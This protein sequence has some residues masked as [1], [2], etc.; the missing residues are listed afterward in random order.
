MTT[1]RATYE[2]HGDLSEFE[3]R[4]QQ[5][6]G[7]KYGLRRRLPRDLLSE[8]VDLLDLAN[9]ET[10]INDF[11]FGYFVTDINGDGNADLLDVPVLEENVNN[12]IFSNHP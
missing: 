12:F 2:R 8:N 1:S 11:Q 4:G 7:E 6:C 3:P 5:D 9:L 10:D